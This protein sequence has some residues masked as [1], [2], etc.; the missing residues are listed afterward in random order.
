[1]DNSAVLD[2]NDRFIQ[3]C[4]TKVNDYYSAA[5]SDK[6]IYIFGSGVYGR[7]LY[8]AFNHLGY[9]KQI[10]AFVINIPSDISSVFDVPVLNV[11]QIIFDNNKDIVV[12]GVQNSSKVVDYL[13]KS[14]ISFIEA[15]YDCSFFQDN[16]MYSVYKCIEV[17]SVADMVEKIRAYYDNV[18]GNEDE[19]LS[20]YE[21]NL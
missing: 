12:V 21:E 15:D 1:M 17:N 6:N 20:L 16:L 9:G 11:S 13:I 10:K 18:L 5:V 19:I 8:Q 4:W 3:G 2:A 7:F 14:E